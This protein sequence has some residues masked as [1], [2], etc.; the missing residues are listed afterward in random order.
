MSYMRLLYSHSIFP[1]SNV[2][3]HSCDRAVNLPGTSCHLGAGKV[4]VEKVVVID[5]NSGHFIKT[6]QRRQYVTFS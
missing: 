2:V 4:S 6:G 3:A 5:N 1:I